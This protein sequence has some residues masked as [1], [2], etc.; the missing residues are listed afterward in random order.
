MLR[1]ITA[2][3][4]CYCQHVRVV[5]PLAARSCTRLS[6]AENQQTVDALYGLSVDIRRVRKMKA[7]VL[8]RTPAYVNEAACLLR[9]LG[10]DSLVIARVI[11]Q[12]PEAILCS[13]EEMQSQQELWMTVC[14]SKKDLVGIIEKFP[15]SFFT[16]AR[17][18]ENQRANIQ[19]FQSLGINKRIV[20]KLMAGAP[21]SFSQPVQQNQRMV[22]TLQDAYLHLGAREDNMK[23]W[24]QKLLSQ[25]PYVL[26]KSPEAM[27]DNLL[28]LHDRGFSSIEL[29]RLLS[30]LK[31]FVTELSPDGMRH[32]LTFSQDT[33]GCSDE[34]LREVI[35]KCPALLYYPVPI[36]TERFQNFLAVGVSMAQ[37]METP[38]VLE[39]TTEIVLYRI[40]KLKAYG[41][42][43]RTG[44]LEA[45]NGTKKDFEKSYGRLQLRRERPMFNP[46]APLIASDD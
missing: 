22:Q 39:L 24:L 30:K 12:H 5:P 26:L 45:L 17:H 21:Q 9:G 41:Y 25:N 18:H 38:T 3:V 13:P 7:W 34:E 43:I 15:A 11:E 42:D 35:L 23:V 20:S 19:F 14:P 6:P 31:G 8:H 4:C 46:V 33:L 10:A 29:Y 37:I 2:T 1:L 28:F 16:S 40:E 36:L 27:Q 44:G 32:T